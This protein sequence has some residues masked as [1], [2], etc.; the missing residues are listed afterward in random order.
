MSYKQ[1]SD[2]ASEWERQLTTA[3]ANQT[4]GLTS[5]RATNWAPEVTF[6]PFRVISRRQMMFPFCCEISQVYKGSMDLGTF[7]SFKE[8]L[9]FVHKL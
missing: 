1:W 3:L 9:R 2:F 5:G 8:V 6:S 4:T 7:S